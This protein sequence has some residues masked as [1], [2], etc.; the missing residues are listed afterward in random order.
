[1]T[2]EPSFAD[3]HRAAA[4]RFTEVVEGVQDW[5]VPTPVKEWTARDVVGHLVEWFPG[6]LQGGSAEQLEPGPSAADDPV[7]AWAHQRDQV[8]ALLEDESRAGA[9]YRS[10][11]L[12]EMPLGQVVDQFYTADVFMHTWDLARATGQDDT[13]DERVVTPMHQGMR[14]MEQMIR[15]SGQFGEE[16]PVKEGATEQERFI[17]FIGRDPYWQPPGR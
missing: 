8:Q 11:M 12:P 13:L 15:G 7:A 17:A 9:T 2:T 6:F 10:D 14:G 3:R 5:D 1:M 16:Q 4:A